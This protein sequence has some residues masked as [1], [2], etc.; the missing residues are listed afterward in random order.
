[1]D[2]I[3]NYLVVNDQASCFDE[4]DEEDVWASAGHTHAVFGLS[5]VDLLHITS[6]RVVA[7][8]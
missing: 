1:M 6:G 7:V 4:A 8:K 3:V 2:A 5:P